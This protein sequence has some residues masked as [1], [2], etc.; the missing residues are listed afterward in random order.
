MKKKFDAVGWTR[1]R[2]IEIDS[3]DDGLSLKQRRDKVFRLLEADPL[4][5][6]FKDRLVKPVETLDEQ[7]KTKAG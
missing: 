4:W 3:E 2:R 5:K 6:K 7:L 1:K